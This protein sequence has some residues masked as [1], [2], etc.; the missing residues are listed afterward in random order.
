MKEDPDDIPEATP[1]EHSEDAE[2]G[3]RS[4]PQASGGEN[5]LK[6][7]WEDEKLAEENVFQGLVE[8]LHEKGEKEVVRILKVC[9]GPF[10]TSTG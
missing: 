1:P 4:G 7:D 2:S 8:R 5:H 3:E 10:S 6:D 9:V